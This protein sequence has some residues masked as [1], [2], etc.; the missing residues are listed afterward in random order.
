MASPGSPDSLP[1]TAEGLLALMDRVST[2][3]TADEA[4][5]TSARSPPRSSPVADMPSDVTALLSSLIT[6]YHHT[7]IR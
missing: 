6:P 2:P 1:N 3:P 4:P 7:A 5:Y